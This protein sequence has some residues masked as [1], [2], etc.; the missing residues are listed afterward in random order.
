MLAWR[1][2]KIRYAPDVC[3]PF[4]GNHPTL[5][6]HLD[7][8][9]WCSEGSQNV[10]TGAIPHVVYSTCGVMAWTYF[11]YVMTNA[12]SSIISAQAM[13]KKIYFPRIIIPLSKAVVGFIDMGITAVILI[14]LMLLFEVPVSGKHHLP[15][16]L[17]PRI[18]RR[19]F[20]CRGFAQLH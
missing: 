13:V 4:V 9:T 7:Y 20:I 5:L 11:A 19:G 14:V 16:H 8:S 1:D 2:F 10:Q 15:A 6:Y 3:R 18:H 17:H 12:G